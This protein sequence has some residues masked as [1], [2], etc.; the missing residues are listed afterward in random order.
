MCFQF[1]HSVIVLDLPFFPSFTTVPAAIP[2][3]FFVPYPL[4]R[5]VHG[6]HV[7]P[8]ILQCTPM[9]PTIPFPSPQSTRPT[10]FA[11]LHLYCCAISIITTAP[12]SHSH[13]S[14][15]PQPL[16]T[17]A[18]NKR[19]TSTKPTHLKTA[20]KHPPPHINPHP[21]LHL[22]NTS[23]PVPRRRSFHRHNHIAQQTS[24]R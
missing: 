14:T 19:T 17:S 2:S 4:L 20:L 12:V 18:T 13:S 10:P 3:A 6:K 23:I 21:L 22:C 8:R 7:L 11:Y 24:R 16:S 15:H 5:S 9:S 1:C